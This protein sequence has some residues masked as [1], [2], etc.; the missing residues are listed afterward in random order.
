M[1]TA[2]LLIDIQNDYF[3]NGKMEL[4][5]PVQT[6]HQAAKV[7]AW[8]RQHHKDTI[9]HVQHI[10]TEEEKGFFLPN[11]EGVNINAVVLPEGEEE[12]IIK[13]T[14]NSFFNTDLAGKLEGKGVMKLVIAGMMT[15][16]CI[17]ATVRAATELGFEVTLI[18]DACT[19]RDLAYREKTVPAQQVHEAFIGALA[20][21][22]AEVVSAE[23]FVR[24]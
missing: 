18:D 20:G 13:H 23:E 6:A 22:Y 9:F 3:P 19:T 12:I 21:V 24:K 7:L 16:M 4:D 14:P 15:H 1:N 11:T 8:F 5:R 17:D 2:L 10:A